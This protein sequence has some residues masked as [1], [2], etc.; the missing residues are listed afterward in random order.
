MSSIPSAEDEYDSYAGAVYTMLLTKGASADALASH[1]LQIATDHM[2]LSAAPS[3]SRCCFDAA[4]A[5]VA[6]RQHF[7]KDDLI[8]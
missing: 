7:E 5:L 4:A 6:L 8:Q 3:L 2:G 1:L